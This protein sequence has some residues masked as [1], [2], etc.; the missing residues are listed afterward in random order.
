MTAAVL[1]GA[2]LGL[3]MFLLVRGLW[4]GRPPLAASL[5][6]LHGGRLAPIPAELPAAGQTSRWRLSLGRAAQTTLAELGIQLHTLRQDL[7]VM[8]RP[9]EAFI[10][11]KVLFAL[12][13]AALFA[14]T[15]AGMRLAG[16][17]LPLLVPVW[18]AITVGV[19]GWFAPD[20]VL[21]S[22]AAARRRAFRH[23]VA[24][25]LDLVAISLAGGTGV[26]GALRGAVSLG[27]GWGFSRLAETLERARLAGETPWAALGRLGEEL[28]VTELRELAASLVLAGHEGAKVRQSL[29]AKATALRQHQLAEVESEAAEAT[30]RMVLPIGMLFFGF[31][32]FLGY[33][34]LAAILTGI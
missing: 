30:E 13:G 33:P 10:A 19:A 26:E 29:T 18:A 17:A 6:L 15:T 22:E 23:A 11:E 12:G 25:F 2:G 9:P 5:A 27:Q 16:V 31:L 14:A 21:R 28:G 8:E 3:G 24:A 20:L 32:V 7:R 4:P 1:G 34:A